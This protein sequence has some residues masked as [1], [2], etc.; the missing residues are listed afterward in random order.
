MKSISCSGS[1]DLDLDSFRIQL[2]T[3]GLELSEI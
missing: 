1:I 3:L 2:Y